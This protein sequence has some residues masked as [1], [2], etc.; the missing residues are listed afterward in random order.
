MPK[1]Q[2]MNSTNSTV[3]KRFVIGDIHGAHIPLQQ[4]LERSGFDKEKDLLITLGDICDGWPHVA[5]C[6]DI[7][8]TCINR[9]DIIGNHDQWFHYWLK[10]GRH[11]D[12]WQQGGLGTVRSY[13]RLIENEAAIFPITD[14]WGYKEYTE[15]Y[16]ALNPADIPDSHRNFFENQILYFKDV[17]KRLFVHAGIY[18]F[19]TLEEQKA[20]R[21]DVFMW[22]RDLWSEALSAGKDGPLRFKEEFSEIFI[23]HTSTVYWTKFKN[24]PLKRIVLPVEDPTYAPMTADILYNLDTGAG[25]SGKLTIMNIDTHEYWQSDQVNT[26]YGDYKPRG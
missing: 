14:I 11:P 1:T 5:E 18:R 25:S 8:L 26:I 21:P 23:G 10:T 9:I 19:Q 17:K 15:Y 7:L 2:L 13:L 6:V 3:G 12:M 24:P 20:S 16:S 4:C 22:D